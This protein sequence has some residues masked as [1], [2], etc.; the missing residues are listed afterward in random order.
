MAFVFIAFDKCRCS[1]L[2]MSRSYI[3][4]WLGLFIYEFQ[5]LTVWRGVKVTVREVEVTSCINVT[6]TICFFAEYCNNNGI[7][8]EKV[9]HPTQIGWV[10]DFSIPQPAGVLNIIKKRINVY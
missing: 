9:T 8:K 1:Y 7:L 2:K 6:I 3:S 5:K 10:V 4:F